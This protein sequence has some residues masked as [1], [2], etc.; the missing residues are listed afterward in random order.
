M[1]ESGIP[2]YLLDIIIR[3]LLTFT[4]DPAINVACIGPTEE[5]GQP[6]RS[7]EEGVPSYLSYL[8]FG[9]LDILF[10]FHWLILLSF[11]PLPMDIQEVHDHP[12]TTK[13]IARKRVRKA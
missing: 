8:V 3:N 13:Q 10:L 9:Y 11:Q 6:F 12:P 4:G 5:P 1:Q 7:D 2:S